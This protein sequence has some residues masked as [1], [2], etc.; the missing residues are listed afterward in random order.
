MNLVRKGQNREYARQKTSRH[1][2]RTPLPPRPGQVAEAQEAIEMAKKVL[3]GAKIPKQRQPQAETWEDKY[4]HASDLISGWIEQGQ[5]LDEIE[6]AQRKQRK[7]A[8]KAEEAKREQEAAEAA[9]QEKLEAERAA[10]KARKKGGKK[11]GKSKRAAAESSGPT[12]DTHP[13]A[14]AFYADARGLGWAVACT[15]AAGQDTVTAARGQEAI[16]LTWVN[17]ALAAAPLYTRADGSQGKL[18]NASDCRHTMAL[19]ALSAEALL[20]RATV[21]ARTAAPSQRQPKRSF[22]F[23]PGELTDAELTEAMQS[24]KVVWLNRISGAEET[25]FVRGSVRVHEGASGRQ[26]TFLGSSW[27]TVLIS[28]ITSISGGHRQRKPLKV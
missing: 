26:I 7:K 2:Q 27:R 16:S 10:L 28:S 9:A 25:E 15:S 8:R 6:K 17:G 4:A 19:P 21:R 1:A 24:R 11:G 14:Q 20:A 23:N 22:V 18:R 5:E 12:G 13:K 3:D